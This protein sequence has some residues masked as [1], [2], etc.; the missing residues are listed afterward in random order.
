MTKPSTSGQPRPGSQ[1]EASS[2][3]PSTQ[4]PKPPVVQP[5]Q[6]PGPN[7]QPEGGPG[8]MPSPD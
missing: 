2:Q 7:D 3:K 5:P 4:K 8:L 6:V 1:P